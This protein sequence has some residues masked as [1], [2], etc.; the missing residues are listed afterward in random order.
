MNIVDAKKSE[1][2]FQHCPLRRNV[3]Y[4]E[5]YDVFTDFD[6]ADDSSDEFIF[7]VTHNKPSI[8]RC[9]ATKAINCSELFATK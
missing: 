1:S 3:K 6:E 9:V 7:Y 2:L 5:K 4:R 8:V